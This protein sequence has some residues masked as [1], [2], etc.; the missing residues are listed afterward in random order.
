MLVQL[1][2]KKNSNE[3]GI[4]RFPEIDTIEV[5]MNIEHVIWSVGCIITHCTIWRISLILF[6]IN[7]NMIKFHFKHTHNNMFYL[8]FKRMCLSAIA[9][10]F[11][12]YKTRS[13]FELLFHSDFFPVCAW[14]DNSEKK[15]AS[16]YT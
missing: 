9:L 11:K 13:Q 12:K 10:Y 3:N 7:F 14:M 15:C 5:N 8:V 2:T 16:N 6:S 4:R 1:H